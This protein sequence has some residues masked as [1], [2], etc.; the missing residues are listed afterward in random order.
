MLCAC[1]FST[2]LNSHH[3][4]WHLHF[5]AD[6]MAIKFGPTFCAKSFNKTRKISI[7]LELIIVIGE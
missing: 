6:E 1:L 5:H 3:R 4:F 7:I 2:Y